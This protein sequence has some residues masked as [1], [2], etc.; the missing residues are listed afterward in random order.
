MQ[1]HTQDV[2]LQYPR[3]FQTDL[4]DVWMFVCF[5]VSVG[6]FPLVT[7]SGE[8]VTENDIQASIFKQC[9][10]LSKQNVGKAKFFQ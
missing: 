5:P 1:V 10:T 6:A 3:N 7:Q 9:V 2:S 8:I 4:T